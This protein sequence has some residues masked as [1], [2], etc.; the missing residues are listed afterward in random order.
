MHEVTRKDYLELAYAL[1]RARPQNMYTNVEARQTWYDCCTEIS[2]VLSK[3]GGFDSKQFF[4][5]AGVPD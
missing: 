4:D 1:K 2:K 5:N 3:S